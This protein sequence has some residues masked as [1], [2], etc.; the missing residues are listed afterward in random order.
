MIDFSNFR[1]QVFSIDINSRESLF[2]QH[3]T[4]ISIFSPIAS[5]YQTC[6]LFNKPFY[7]N[8]KYI[9]QIFLPQIAL[10]YIQTSLSTDC[11]DT[12]NPLVAFGLI[13]ILQG[14][15]YGH[16]NLYFSDKMNISHNMD[17]RNY[18]KGPFFAAMRDIISQGLPFY[19]TPLLIPYINAKINNKYNNNNNNNNNINE[20]IVLGGL[21]I[22][23]TYLSHPF[24]CLQIFIQNEPYNTQIEI[25]KKIITQYKWSLF[26]RGITGRLILL[27]VTNYSNHMFLRYLWDNKSTN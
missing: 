3:S 11:K 7:S 27:L 24:H 16:S 14:G 20:F 1:K 15:V 4:L 21:S 17:I 10:R 26:Y 12:F 18:F 2:L 6:K 25:A 5:L 9:P 22:G 19:I 13:G 23:S 8:L